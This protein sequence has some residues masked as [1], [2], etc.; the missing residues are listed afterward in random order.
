MQ[1]DQNKDYG[2]LFTR[3]QCCKIP[4]VA[5][6][7]LITRTAIEVKCTFVNCWWTLIF[8]HRTPKKIDCHKLWFYNPYIK[9]STYVVDLRY[10][11][12]CILLVNESKFKISKVCTIRLL[13]YRDYLGLCS[14]KDSIPFIEKKCQSQNGKLWSCLNLPISSHLYFTPLSFTLEFVS[15]LFKIYISLFTVSS[16]WFQKEKQ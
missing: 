9:F 13:R 11:K 4:Q 15:N 16:P 7:H 2:H 12:L 10:F 8:S 1:L 6:E 14:G 5:W 3:L